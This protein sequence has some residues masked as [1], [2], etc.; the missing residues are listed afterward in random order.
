MA[1]NNS[2]NTQKKIQDMSISSYLGNV[3]VKS[4]LEKVLGNKTDRFIASLTSAVTNNPDLQTCDKQTLVNAALLGNSLNLSPSQQLGHFYLVPFKDRNNGR[5][6]AQFQ[7][8]Y[9]GYIQLAMRSGQYKD[10]DVIEV[11]QGELVNYSRFKGIAEFNEIE[12]FEERAKAPTVGY[13]A[14]FELLNGF[15]KQI[16][17]SREQMQIHAETYS[18]GYR[19]DLK[20]NTKYTFWSKDF[21]G[22]AKKTMLRQLLSKWGM[23]SID[24]Q[25]AYTS[26]MGQI[27]DDGSVTYIDN[28]GDTVSVSKQYDAEFN[29][30]DDEPTE[31][32][33]EEEENKEKSF[34]EQAMS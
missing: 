10:L 7:L 30:D 19:A 25:N 4:T 13:Y 1:V 14:Y 23:L 34:F 20:K 29:E 28:S 27:N 22:M 26:D 5:V 15:R 6:V 2:L 3:N 24:M 8:G 16:Y 31:I 33:N 17:W 32:T 9:K 12:N 11:K 18:Q 21:D